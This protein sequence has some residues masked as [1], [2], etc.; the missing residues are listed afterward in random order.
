M[1]LVILG[2]LM[3][4]RHQAPLIEKYGIAGILRDLK[5]TTGDRKIIANL[6][7]PLLSNI[8]L[9]KHSSTFSKFYGAEGIAKQ[10][11][12]FGFEALSLANNHIFDFGYDG[13][14]NTQKIL[15]QNSI[16]Y[17]GAGLNKEACNNSCR[18]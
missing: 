8:N 11:S 2:D 3:L 4:G 18:D 10:L 5:K 1:G 16:Q 7:C 17:F 15:N 13:L 12:N 14:I 9:K 6:E